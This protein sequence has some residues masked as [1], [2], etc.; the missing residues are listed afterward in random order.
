VGVTGGSRELP[1]RKR[2][3]RDNNIIIII[4]I[5][6]VIVSTMGMGERRNIYTILGTKLKDNKSY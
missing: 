1:G 2:V 5:I 6:I 4:I 3:T